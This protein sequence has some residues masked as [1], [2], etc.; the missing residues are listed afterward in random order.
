M[1]RRPENIALAIWRKPS[2]PSLMAIFACLGSTQTVCPC[3]TPKMTLLLLMGDGWLIEITKGGRTMTI[4]VMQAPTVLRN[5]PSLC[6]FGALCLSTLASR[7]R[8][9]RV[10]LSDVAYR[11]LNM[12]TRR[13]RQYKV[14]QH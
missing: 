9:L 1:H 14:L 7:G 6:Y 10:V 3:W 13:A 12:T 11:T 4:V 5:Q 8:H 2:R